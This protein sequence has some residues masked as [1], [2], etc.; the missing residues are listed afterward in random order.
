[1]KTTAFNSSKPYQSALERDNTAKSVPQLQWLEQISRVMDNAFQIPGTNIRFG[2]DPVIGLI[3]GLGELVTFGISGAL[4][5]TMA[6][7]G[8]SRKVMLMMAGNIL[9][10]SALGAIPLVGDLFDFGFKS[11]QRNLNLLRKHYQEGK[12]QGS[13][14]GIII[15]A[16]IL[17]LALAGGLVFAIWKLV[18]YIVGLF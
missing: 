13:G 10:D 4:L 3:P 8:V 6:R 18:T 2:L 17:M 12:H 15:V 11:N 16:G 14:K 5:L 7:Y 9:L 1:M